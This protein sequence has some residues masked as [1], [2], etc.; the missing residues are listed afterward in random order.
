MNIR[1]RDLQNFRWVLGII[2]IALLHGASFVQAANVERATLGAGCFWCV[3]AIYERI[4][5]VIAVESG[6]AGGTE[7]DPTYDS[8]GSG[9]TGH[10][11]VVQV[12]FDPAIVSYGQLID[13]FWKTHDVTDPTGVEPDFGPQYRSIL[14]YENEAQRA[15]IEVSKATA[16]KALKRPIATE[17]TALTRFYP[18][19]AYHQDFVARHLN[20]P[21][22][23]S[24][25][26]PKLEKLGLPM[27]KTEQSKSKRFRSGEF[28]FAA[29]AIMGVFWALRYFRTRSVAA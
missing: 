25:S 3:E 16:Q 13:W 10:A 9:R 22:V 8:V 5:G 19:E 27:S 15:A 29:F 18:A 11:E 26:L 14:L 4:P 6:Y 28:V 20:H 1:F 24:I 23:R 7:P 12:T 2:S 17:I 21:Y